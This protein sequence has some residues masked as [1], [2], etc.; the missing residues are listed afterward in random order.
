MKE[1]GREFGLAFLRNF[2]EAAHAFGMIVSVSVLY[3]LIRGRKRVQRGAVHLSVFLGVFFS[4]HIVISLGAQSI[5]RYYRPIVPVMAVFA[6]AGLF[7]FLKDVRRRWIGVAVLICIGAWYTLASL[8]APIRPHRAEQVEAG[9]WLGSYDAEYRGYVVSAYSQPAFYAGMQFVS[10]KVGPRCVERLFND[11]RA[12]KYWILER[13]DDQP[14]A[15]IVRFLEE[16]HWKL[17]KTFP[18][19]NIRIYLNPQWV[20]RTI[21]LPV[22][23]PA[24][25][26]V[27][28]IVANHEWQRVRLRGN[29]ADPVIVAGMI[30]SRGAD[31]AVVRL[32]ILDRTQF[33]IRLQEWENQDG[34]HRREIVY[35]L[36]AERGRNSLDDARALEADK[37]VATASYPNWVNRRF[38]RPFSSRPVVLSQIV[39]FE[40]A[41]AAVT[42][43]RDVSQEGFLLAVQGSEAKRGQHGEEEVGYIALEPGLYRLGD[44]E[45]E[46]ALPDSKVTSERTSLPTQF[47]P[48]EIRVEEERSLDAEMYHVGEEVGYLAFG[49]NIAYL[50]QLQSCTGPDTA[51][52]ATLGPPDTD[53]STAKNFPQGDAF[54]P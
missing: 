14:Y 32:R 54:A 10:A 37:V 52:L 18:Q 21:E 17:L 48:I 11:R 4:Y 5:D 50:A 40:D 9:R 20:T 15:A 36:V 53:V 13:R 47:G 27:G 6:A 39:S 23:T 24:G 26:E 16:Y 12:P 3:W 29:F 25:L 46:A 34:L 43:Q 33:E 1:L 49:S 7:C 31:P 30:S 35:Y 8:R 45:W 28:L 44:W 19:R 2:L 42:R 41:A 22:V 51:R 38:G